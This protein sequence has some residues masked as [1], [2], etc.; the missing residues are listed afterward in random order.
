MA[1]P[2]P[3]AS[4][5]DC[6]RSCREHPG[7]EKLLPQEVLSRAL[8]LLLRREQQHWFCGG[9]DALVREAA[10]FLLRLFQYD[11]CQPVRV[12]RAALRRC[13]H[14]CCACV[15]HLEYARRSSSSS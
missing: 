15:L 14:R 12:W 5:E 1:A 11:D 4:L 2:S 8:S 7:P 3:D 6:L 9:A 13:L 10:A